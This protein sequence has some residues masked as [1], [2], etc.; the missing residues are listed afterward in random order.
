MGLAKTFITGLLLAILVLVVN[1]NLVTA[2]TK[3]LKASDGKKCT[4]IGTKGNDTLKGSNKVDV[5]CGL[6]GNDKIQGLGGNDTI[7][8]GSG[9]D[10]IVAGS[11]DDKLYGGTGNDTLK[12]ESG[13][14]YFKGNEGIDTVS[15]SEKKKDLNISLN[16]KKDDGEKNERDL[17]S[18]DV[19]NLTG[20]TG[21]DKI[22]GNDH[23][24]TLV[25]LAGNDKIE[26]NK[27]NDEIVGKEG[28]DILKGNQGDD[29]IDGGQGSNTCY[30]DQEDSESSSCQL[31]KDLGDL[32]VHVKG[33]IHNSDLKGCYFFMNSLIG[34]EPAASGLIDKNGHFE[35]DAFTG[36][37][38][39]WQVGKLFESGY[40]DYPGKNPDCMS[41]VTLGG[42]MFSLEIIKNMPDFSITL[43]DVIESTISVKNAAGKRV[44][45]LNSSYVS[46]GQRQIPSSWDKDS[47]YNLSIPPFTTQANQDQKVKVL[48]GNDYDIRLSGKIYGMKISREFEGKWSKKV[49]LVIQ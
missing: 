6:G 26:G 18:G 17:I 48:E 14:D 44:A 41:N 46:G 23:K 33:T 5:I 43:P 45:G 22:Q 16:N 3:N 9:N 35:F 10:S 47:Y 15:Y 40:T 21:N 12:G 42:N 39:N 1:E 32:V 13:S 4:I 37:Y 7:D 19:E 30:L 36:K 8:G 27:G 28:S 34:E 25:G 38:Y 2:S 24:N 29:H 31:L 49:N 20:G 11:G